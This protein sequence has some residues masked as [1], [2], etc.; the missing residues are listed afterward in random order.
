[1][2]YLKPL[3]IEVGM[4]VN[5]YFK[6]DGLTFLENAFVAEIGRGSINVYWLWTRLHK[7]ELDYYDLEFVSWSKPRPWYKFFIWVRYVNSKAKQK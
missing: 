1:M 7:I 6:R 2:K 3:E 5:I 4:F